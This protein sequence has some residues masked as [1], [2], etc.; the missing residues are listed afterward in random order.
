MHRGRGWPDPRRSVDALRYIGPRISERF[1]NRR[2]G[3]YTLQDLIDYINGHSLA[4]NTNM[5]RYVFLNARNRRCVFR[6]E[7]VNHR[8][9]TKHWNQ[10]WPNPPYNLPNGA[11]NRLGLVAGDFEYCVRRYNRCGWEIVEAYLRRRR[12]V[13]QARIPAAP[14]RDGY[15][16]PRLRSDPGPAW[17]LRQARGEQEEEEE[18][19][20][21]GLEEE[22]EAGEIERNVQ[23]FIREHG[24]GRHDREE[25][26][27]EEVVPLLRPGEAVEQNISIHELL[28][29]ERDAAAREA[30]ETVQRFRDAFAGELSD[31]DTAQRI[32]YVL[33]SLSEAGDLAQIDVNSLSDLVGRSPP[34][35]RRYIKENMNGSHRNFFVNPRWG[36]YALRERLYHN[37]EDRFLR[38]IR[39]A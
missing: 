7:S 33:W 5:F 39:R 37:N 8:T 16:R 23:E 26:E 10:P 2:F 18:E 21:G 29:R 27:E 1:A 35:I 38:R 6:S 3:I 17:C 22:E 4:N 24:R 34:T 20:E 19:E 30:R 15:C 9:E 13:D 25:E 36:Q 11:A 32:A 14:D 28:Q 12:D 31:L